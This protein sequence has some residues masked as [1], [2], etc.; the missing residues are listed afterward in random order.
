MNPDK[1]ERAG[2]LTPA[3]KRRMDH[4]R[5]I[6]NKLQ[7]EGYQQHDLTISMVRA[8][9]VVLI[10]A[11]PLF[12]VLLILFR[13]LNPGS[14]FHGQAE[15][16][17]SMEIL[18]LAAFLVVLVL[19]TVIHELI[20]GF[21]WGLFSEHHF[22]DIEFGVMWKYGAAYC[23]CK[24]PLKKSQYIL[25]GIMPLIVLG[26]IPCI[27]G[28]AMGSLIVTLFGGIMT[29]GAGGDIMILLQLIRFKTDARDVVI[30]D[31]PTKGGSVVFT[32]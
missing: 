2:E 30:Y 14:G 24:V 32:R 7:N 27:A 4:F 21:V 16:S 29:L 1:K 9:I 12:A 17:F 15:M 11:V 25:G 3:E 22:K 13:K 8:Q 10:A 19:L 28:I 23:T 31:H 6:C 5:E 20:H 26:I 18:Q